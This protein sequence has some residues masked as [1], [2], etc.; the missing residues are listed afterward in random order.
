[1]LLAVDE[2]RHVGQV[3]L[4]LGVGVEQVLAVVPAFRD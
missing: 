4:V 2:A 1:M 3:L